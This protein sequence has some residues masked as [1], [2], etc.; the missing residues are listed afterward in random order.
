MDLSIEDVSLVKLSYSLLIERKANLAQ[1]FYKILFEMAPL[2]KPMF[3]GDQDKLEIHFN[4][5]ISSVSTNID[6]FEYL[7]PKIFALGKMHK[8]FSVKVNQFAVVKNTLILSIQYE[9]K[10]DCS[11]AIITAWERYYDNIAAIMI[12]GLLDED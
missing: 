9:L 10:E 5:L 11:D 1:T 6:D 7:K 3:T 12:Q 2:V 4:E 8:G